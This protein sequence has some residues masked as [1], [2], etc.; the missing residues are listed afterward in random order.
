MVETAPAYKPTFQIEAQNGL[1]CPECGSTKLYR[2]GL[3]YL[4]DGSNV[5][6]WLCRNCG[7]RFSE[8]RKNLKTK[9]D[10]NSFRQVCGKAGLP[11]NLTG[12]AVLALAE[13]N[14]KT[15]SMAAGATSSETNQTNAKG[16]IVEFA[17]WLKKNGK[18]D[19]T[20]K[21]WTLL[22]KLIADKGFDLFNPEK[23]KEAI[24]THEC[25]K[26]TKKVMV[27]AYKSFAKFAG[28]TWEP[29]SY[30]RSPKIPFIPLEREIDDL[31]ACSSKRTAALLQALKESGARLSEIL[32]LKWTDVDFERKVVRIEAE[33]GSNPRILKISDKLVNMLSL[34]PKSNIKIFGGKNK[35]NAYVESLR[36]ARKKAAF[37]LQNPRL[38]LIHYHTLRHWKGTMLY[39]ET[40][41]PWHVK[42]VLG[43]KSL[44]STEL[45]IN[46]EQAIFEDTQEEFH[47]KTAQ[48]PEEI[49]ALLE[50]GFEYVCSKD[51]LM[52]FRKRK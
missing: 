31:I 19:S 35:K 46:I 2:D 28:I 50:I 22:L 39:H 9:R 49:K 26:G 34:L 16:K 45:Y 43:H 11:K 18:A 37:K 7:F 36:K 17:W 3:R 27:D 30:K 40:K 5:Q 42:K 12:W 13:V 1:C 52:F 44:Q 6:R 38:L 33:K 41:D 21:T 4:A 10:N 25:S 47:V 32:E 48:T 20:I 8:K 24:A 14:G 15:G 23:V 29:P 51:G